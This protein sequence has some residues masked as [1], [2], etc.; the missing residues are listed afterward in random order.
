VQSQEEEQ[1]ELSSAA[2]KSLNQSDTTMEPTICHVK[3]FVKNLDPK[4]V[5]STWGM[6]YCGGA[7]VVEQDLQ[8][9]AQEYKLDLHIESF[10]W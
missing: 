8:Q 1:E 3:T 6:L 10:G 9:I 2:A 5:L 4:K 7:K